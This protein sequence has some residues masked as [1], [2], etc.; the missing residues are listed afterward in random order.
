MKN[1]HYT[2]TGK[3]GTESVKISYV[4]EVTAMLVKKSKKKPDIAARLHDVSWERMIVFFFSD[5]F[6][7]PC[8]LGETGQNRCCYSFAAPVSD[9]ATDEQPRYGKNFGIAPVSP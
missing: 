5:K 3:Y 7:F 9:G 4:K 8:F 1:Q 2:E 6:S